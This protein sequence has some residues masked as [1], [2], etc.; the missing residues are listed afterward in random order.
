VRH[1]Q[2]YGLT[3]ELRST[4]NRHQSPTPFSQIFTLAASHHPTTLCAN[5]GSLL[6]LLAALQQGIA[7]QIL[8]MSEIY[9]ASV[10]I[11]AID[12]VRVGHLEIQG[13]LRS[14]GRK[15]QAWVKRTAWLKVCDNCGH[16]RIRFGRESRRMSLQGLVETWEAKTER[17]QF[18]LEKEQ[19]VL[20]HVWSAKKITKMVVSAGVTAF[21]LFVLTQ[22]VLQFV[23]IREIQ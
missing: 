2:R 22:Q 21:L 18:G 9:G 17:E 12:M 13:Q 20:R 14:L 16:A 23:L 15:G 4:F 11:G 3:Q 7:A 6:E 5:A 1:Q 10:F 8:E 19:C